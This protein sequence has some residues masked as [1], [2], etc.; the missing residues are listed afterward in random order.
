MRK[1][2]IVPWSKEWASIFEKEAM[3]LNEIFQDTAIHIHHIGST[4][5][6][7]IGYAKPIIDILIVVDDIS[8]IDRLNSSMLELG[9]E[10][11]GEN[12]ISGRRF[13]QKGGDQRTH[14][15]HVFQQGDK[16]IN[17]HLD[18]KRYLLQ[19]PEQAARYRQK[20]LELAT[21]YPDDH[22]RYQEGKQ[23]LVSELARLAKQWGEKT[24]TLRD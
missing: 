15:V 3:I 24:R 18:F 2:N 22:H 12:G 1:T 4:S 19:H 20:K 23:E 10:V 14:H 21:Q 7:T 17:F 9:Y 8:S 11:K 16:Q 6:K 5:I 13:F